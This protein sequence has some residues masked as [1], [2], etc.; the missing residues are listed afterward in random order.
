VQ[1]GKAAIHYMPSVDQEAAVRELANGRVD[2]VMD[3]AIT[4]KMR[5]Q[6]ENRNLEVGFTILT[7]LVIG[8]AVK[9]DN[10]EIRR[11]VLEGMRE[12][13][14]TGKLKELLAKY[15]LSEFAQPVELRR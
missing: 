9:K 8:P 12:L 10:D 1:H 13:E 3:G 11:A 2:F 15:G 5:A 6:A 14:G 4:A 7:D